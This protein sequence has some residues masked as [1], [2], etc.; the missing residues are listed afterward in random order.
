MM[1]EFSSIL[2]LLL[3]QTA[4]TYDCIEDEIVC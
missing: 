2:T 4:I 1:I 3:K